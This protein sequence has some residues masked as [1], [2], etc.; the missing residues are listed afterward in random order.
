LHRRLVTVEWARTC[1]K[2]RGIGY[3]L[4]RKR[5]ARAPA[6][7]SARNIPC[8]G[9]CVEGVSETDRKAG[10]VSRWKRAHWSLCG[11]EIEVIEARCASLPYISD[12]R[13]GLDPVEQDTVACS[14]AGGNE[15]RLRVRSVCKNDD[16]RKG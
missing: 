12:T 5:K 4:E 2:V 7:D 10:R 9:R 13:L 15:L 11:K 6:R 16:L 3:T 1:T 14:T 8:T